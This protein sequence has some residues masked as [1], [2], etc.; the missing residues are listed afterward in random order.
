MG[1]AYPKT[2]AVRH[3]NEKIRAASRSG[4]VFTALSDNV[5][6]KEGIIYGCA[7]SENFE[8]VHIRAENEIDR[9]KMRGSKYIQS[10][11]GDTY[12][13]VKLDLEDGKKVMFSGTSCQVAGLRA[14]LEKKYENLFCVDIVCHGVPSYK[15]WK[16]YLQWQETRVHAKVK[17]V[18]FRNKKRFGWRKHIETLTFNNGKT[19]CSE[20]FKNLFYSH[21]SLRPS[22]YECPYKTVMHPGDV[23]IAD[24]WGIEMVAP[25]LDDNGGVSLVLV[26]NELGEALLGEVK[27]KLFWRE[28]NL[29]NSLQPPLKGPFP[30]P[31]NRMQFWDDFFKHDFD[32]IAKK[33]GGFGIWN[34]IKRYTRKIVC[35][36][37]KSRCK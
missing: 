25:E 8:A 19:I 1:V 16:A 9:N 24:Y 30:M 10:R 21:T 34:F 27:E 28:T 23:T 5:L 26:N 20:V 17:N 29:E 12:K 4:G 18:D 22:C 14:F 33:Y 36:L 3:K 2:Y 31:N 15:V 35:K 32:Y 13:R 37:V 6:N 7:L 11:L